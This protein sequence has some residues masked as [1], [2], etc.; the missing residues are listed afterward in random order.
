MADANNVETQ[1]QLNELLTERKRIVSETTRLFRQQAQVTNELINALGEAQLSGDIARNA[2][3][4][5]NSLRDAAAAA[6]EFSEKQQDMSEILAESMEEQDDGFESL[7]EQYQK[8]TAE[9]S[10]WGAASVGFIDGISKGFTTLSHGLQGVISLAATAVQGIFSISKSILSIPFKIFNAFVAEANRGGGG[11]E[12]WKAYENVRKTFGDFH[13]DMAKNVISAARSMRGELAETGLSTFRVTGF[14]WDRLNAIRELAT[15][16]GAVFHEFGLHIAENAE[17]MVA[18][19]KGLGLSNEQMKT[20]AQLTQGTGKTFEETL[21]TVTNFSTSLGKQ[22]GISQKVIARDVGMMSQDLK[23]FGSV[24][25]REMAQLSTYTRRLGVDF[26]DLLGIVDKFDNFED[27]ADSAARLAQAFG[28]NIDAMKMIK[29]Q[30][31]GKRIEMLRQSFFEAGKDISKLTRQERNYLAATAGIEDQALNAVFALK[32]QGK[33]YDEVAQA[34]QTAE[35]QQITQAEAMQ[36]LAASIERIVLQGHRMGGFFDRFVRGLRIGIRWNKDFWRVMRNIRLSLWATEH[37][38]RRV[39]RAFITMFPGMKQF[40]RGVGDF[41]SPDK[42]RKMAGK[43]VQGFRNFFKDL[44]DPSTAED[45]LKNLLKALNNAFFDMVDMESSAMGKIVGGLKKAMKAV[46]QIVLSGLKIAMEKV[47]DF[48][49]VITR[50]VRG[51]TDFATAFKE[52]FDKAGQGG[53]SLLFDIWYEISRQLGPVAGQL[54]DAFV[55]LM[56]EVWDHVVAWVDKHFW[57]TLWKILG[58]KPGMIA[59]AMIVVPGIAKGMAS[60]LGA[61]LSNPHVTSSLTKSIASMG[62]QKMLMMGARG[63][64]MGAAVALAG[65]IAY[66]FYEAWSDVAEQYEFID[67]KVESA[68]KVAAQRRQQISGQNKE[69]GIQK[70]ELEAIAMAERGH[71]ADMLIALGKKHDLTKKDMMLRAQEAATEENIRLRGIEAEREKLMFQREQVRSAKENRALLG[72]ATMGLS[73]AGFALG[74]SEDDINKEIARLDKAS[75]KAQAKVQS[76][77][78]PFL[79][80]GTALEVSPEQR[81]RKEATE[82]LKRKLQMGGA[83]VSDVELDIFNRIKKMKPKQVEKTLE[84]FRETVKPMLIGK[85]GNGG[86]RADLLDIGKAFSDEQIG[87]SILAIESIKMFG[88][89]ADGLGVLIKVGQI[90]PEEVSKAMT[91]IRGSVDNLADKSLLEG[92][93]RLNASR[94]EISD[95]IVNIESMGTAIGGIRLFHDEFMKFNTNAKKSKVGDAD[96]AEMPAVKA[97]SKM[98]TAAN[99]ITKHLSGINIKTLR[100]QIENLGRA[101]GLKGDDKFRIENQKMKFDVKV[102]VFLD[103]EAVTSAIKDQNVFL[104]STKASKKT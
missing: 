27:A 45:A 97:I 50:V 11:V 104:T 78:S 93:G 28:I 43:V 61:A 72:V 74:P 96:M 1:K 8:G 87:Q 56:K 36:R 13:T 9:T 47:R 25:V 88:Q 20:M 76:I 7:F 100:P 62:W 103:P 31:P 30:D 53:A 46:G 16:M 94:K 85:D 40:I 79:E 66:K 22:F 5:A 49:K 98:I 65:L 82:S 2:Q 19:Q 59:A 57:P 35:Q 84:T 68:A 67:K 89:A 51:E 92:F 29:E 38:G 44:G 32:N 34:G 33:S 70:E 71:Q 86:L 55:E 58:S 52:M 42:F 23:K 102:E 14:L 91:T 64:L 6:Q 3:S 4:T 75:A 81:K 12:L 90:K 41:F 37:A 80:A 15:E 54:K 63:G 60:G 83:D 73:E 48:F 17:R 10:S 39:G 24:G 77:M 101:L 18:Y 21:R 99:E 69:L 26:K 95:G